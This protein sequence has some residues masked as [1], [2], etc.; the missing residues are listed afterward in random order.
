MV[1]ASGT[2][3]TS[4][5]YQPE[6]GQA[7]G[8][9]ARV[10]AGGN[11]MPRTFAL[12]FAKGDEVMSGLTD[13]ASRENIA[14]AHLQGIGAFSSALLGWFDKDRKEY[15]HIPID[16]IVECLSLLGDVG[17]VEGKRTLHV[18]ASVGL[19]DGT[20][21]GGHMLSAHVFPTLELFATEGAVRF[22][23]QR[24]RKPRSSCLISASVDA[25]FGSEV[26]KAA[27]PQCDELSNRD[28]CGENQT[29][30]TVR[31]SH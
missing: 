11:G 28:T 7:P 1:F 27:D 17:V 13:W 5:S 8:M 19:P 15:R 25:T 16:E 2:N 20:V 31:F 26:R 12:I 22:T 6:P 24:M 3:Y 30:R 4:T 21:K 29:E 23:R 10:I 18:H 14:S 9:Q